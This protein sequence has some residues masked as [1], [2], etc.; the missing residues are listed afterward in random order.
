MATFRG[1]GS[2]ESG[3]AFPTEVELEAA[4]AACLANE[5]A[6][7]ASAAAALISENNA[8][9]SEDDAAADLVL[10]NADVVLTH[11]DVV[12]TNADVATTTQ[13]AIDTAADVISAAGSASNASAFAS[14]ALSSALDANNAKAQTQLDAAATAADLLLTDLDQQSCA[15][16]AIIT[17]AD[18]VITNADAATTTQDA[19]DTAADAAV[20]AQ[21][22]IDT[23]ADAVATAADAVSTA[24]DVLLT[25]ADV[26]SCEAAWNSFDA[27]YLGEFATA[28]TLDNSGG[29]LVDG[30]LYWDTAVTIMYVRDTAAWVQWGG[31]Y[32]AKT[33]GTYTGNI[34]HYTSTFTEN[35]EGNTSTALTIDWTISN[36]AKC[37]ATGAAT[38]TFTAPAGPTNLVLKVV[39]DATGSRVITWPATVKWPGGT[40]PTLTTTASA[41]DIIAMYY[42]GTNYHASSSLNSS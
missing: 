16:N 3:S 2:V 28:P 38:L 11:A 24:A 40:A 33:G 31:D 14:S 37:T 36:K 25:A 20:T 30:Q 8:Q 6:A 12:L 26:V 4:I 27:V 7:A 19:I 35:D 9:S 22:A 13:D 34:V 15:A 39:Q 1:S 23:A 5:Q 10:T 29:A 21:D 17:A 42:D 41:T 32:I 18:V